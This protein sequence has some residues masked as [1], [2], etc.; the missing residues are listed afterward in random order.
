MVSDSLTIDVINN[1]TLVMIERHFPTAFVFEM[2]ISREYS[3][4]NSCIST[5][6]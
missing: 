3:F 6:T 5:H 4:L 1:N 2:A